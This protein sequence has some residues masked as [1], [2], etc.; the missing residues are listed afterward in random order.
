ML[1]CCDAP[2]KVRYRDG[3]ASGS[4]SRFCRRHVTWELRHQGTNGSWLMAHRSAGE[5]GTEGS[6]I[7]PHCVPPQEA[8]RPQHACQIRFRT[9]ISFLSFFGF[10]SS[11]TSSSDCAIGR[12][13]LGVVELADTVELPNWAPVQALTSARQGPLAARPKVKFNLLHLHFHHHH[14]HTI[15]A[16][17]S[18]EA[19]SSR[20]W[21]EAQIN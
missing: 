13:Y 1:Q 16:I 10:L 20:S 3:S 7:E 6:G 14:H 12:K 21:V 17:A 2:K 5:P 9:E 8:H 19:H 15:P 4:G 11:C 18:A